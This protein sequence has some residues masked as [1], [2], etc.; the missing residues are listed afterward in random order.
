MKQVWIYREYRME[1]VI[2]YNIAEKCLLMRFKQTGPS[3]MDINRDSE[4]DIC[5]TFLK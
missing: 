4:A 1:G 5:W 3:H 2:L